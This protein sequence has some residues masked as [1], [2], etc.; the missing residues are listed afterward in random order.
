MV[1]SICKIHSDRELKTFDLTDVTSGSTTTLKPTKKLGT[2]KLQFESPRQASGS[3][4]SSPTTWVWKGS[5]FKSMELY[6][7]DAQGNKKSLAVYIRTST[8]SHILRL[9]T[10]AMF[11]RAPSDSNNHPGDLLRLCPDLPYALATLWPF[12]AMYRKVLMSEFTSE[13]KV[14]QRSAGAQPSR[15]DAAILGDPLK[16]ASMAQVSREGQDGLIS[17]PVNTNGNGQD[18]SDND[19]NQTLH[20]DRPT[21]SFPHVHE[22]A[23]EGAST[24][25]FQGAATSRNA[26]PSPSRWN[27]KSVFRRGPGQ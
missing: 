4:A 12:I 24:P 21:A 8:R 23:A 15:W 10:D 27:I 17:R 6:S 2:H 16:G 25:R 7:K 11:V 3:S 20:G 22:D 13:R 19:D 5:V 26:S 9:Y 1:Q 14:L 18:I